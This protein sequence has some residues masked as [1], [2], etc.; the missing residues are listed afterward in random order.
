MRPSAEALSSIL[1]TSRRS[2]TMISARSAPSMFS[3]VAAL[4][5]CFRSPGCARVTKRSKLLKGQSRRASRIQSFGCGIPEIA[6]KTISSPKLLLGD[7]RMTLAGTGWYQRDRAARKCGAAGD[8]W[9][10]RKNHFA[11]RLERAAQWQERLREQ[12]SQVPEDTEDRWQRT[13]QMW[14]RIEKQLNEQK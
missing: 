2:Q 3:K 5:R 11:K 6:R 10:T 14:E 9:M 12:E 4:V 1:A 7:S 8:V 13:K